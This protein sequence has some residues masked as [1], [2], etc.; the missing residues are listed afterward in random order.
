MTKSATDTPKKNKVKEEENVGV[1]VGDTNLDGMGQESISK[2]MTW[3]EWNEWV[4]SAD[5]WRK[6]I[7]DRGNSKGPE[8]R[9]KAS[10]KR[11]EWWK[12]KPHTT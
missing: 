3:F 7:P 5:F 1:G 11:G 4:S 8:V 12:M 6:H 2:E 10:E 9:L